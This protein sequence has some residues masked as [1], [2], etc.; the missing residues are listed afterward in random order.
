MKKFILAIL[1]LTMFMVSCSEKPNETKQVVE[2]KKIKKYDYFI[3]SAIPKK[4][5]ESGILQD[6]M[7]W[8]GVDTIYTDQN[9]SGKIKIG[10]YEN[11]LTASEKGL[12]LYLDSVITNY[13]LLKKDSVSSDLYENFIFIGKYLNDRP[14][15]YSANLKNKKVKLLW[16]KW[17]KKILSLDFSP[18]NDYAYFLTAYRYGKNS[19]FPHIVDAKLFKYD[20][21]SNEV[22]MVK[23]FGKG[24]SYYSYWQNENE[25]KTIYTSID[26]TITSN[27][28]QLNTVFNKTGEVISDSIFNFDLEKD[29]FPLIERKKE[30]K[31]SSDNKYMLLTEKKD[32]IRF[33]KVL[34]K[35]D[36]K[37]LTIHKGEFE[38]DKVEWKD[39]LYLI[40]ILNN[41]NSLSEL[42]TVKS[43]IVVC[44]LNNFS[45][46]KMFKLPGL[47]NIQIFSNLLIY[48]EGFG[49]N[50]ELVFYDFVSNKEYW[51]IKVP[52][53]CGV[54]NIPV[55]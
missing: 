42:E 34:R 4:D 23:D 35:S 46:S 36:N 40:A 3:L 25:Y 21:Y 10:Y 20:I 5:F 48:D 15:L 33:T 37:V 32:S 43:E 28:K 52:G 49:K 19:S 13:S 6:S 24:V 51:R 8:Y 1:T 16:S 53:G 50:S 17:G 22:S 54:K 14:A 45:I 29:G 55:E 12:S 2:K 47:R 44:D 27:I 39:E 7:N 11:L 26:T 41:K 38:L 31:N 30:F 18:A 9:D